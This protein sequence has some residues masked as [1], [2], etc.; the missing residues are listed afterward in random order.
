MQTFA[1]HIVIYYHFPMECFSLHIT[2]ITEKPSTIICSLSRWFILG[3]GRQQNLKCVNLKCVTYTLP[4]WAPLHRVPLLRIYIRALAFVHK[5]KPKA[6]ASMQIDNI[7]DVNGPV[8]PSSTDIL[9]IMRKVCSINTLLISK[10]CGFAN[11]Y[12]TNLL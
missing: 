3:Q 4:I 1:H 7:R 12:H 11:F 2:Y 9:P 5:S 10:N 8:W 6:R